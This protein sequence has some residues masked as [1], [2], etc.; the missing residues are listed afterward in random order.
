MSLRLRLALWYG[1]LTG[2]IVLL[3]SALGYAI[4]SRGQHAALDQALQGAVAHVVGGHQASD[5]QGELAAMLATPVLPD[6]SI[7]ITDAGGEV[8]AASPNATLAGLVEPAEVVRLA[9]AQ[10]TSSWGGRLSGLVHAS[11]GEGHFAVMVVDGVRWRLYAQ[12]A[13]QQGEYVLA[14]APLASMDAAD[15]AL[16]RLI[17][18]LALFGMAVTVIAGGLLA[19]RALR[20]LATITATAHE[21]A[22][23]GNPSARVPVGVRRDELGQL[24]ATFN[25]MLDSLAEAH[26]GQ[27][28]F[29]ADASH[30]L[31]APLTALQANLELL[32]RQSGSPAEQQAMIG[33]ASR[34]AH[35]LSRLVADLLALARADA[36]IPLRHQSVELDRVV[37]DAFREARHL[38]R[39]QRL[40]LGHF[41][42][43]RISGDP[44]RLKQVV[45][46]LLDNAIKYTAPEG[47]VTVTLQHDASGAR[48]EVRDS[49]VGIPKEALPHVWERFY[50]ADPARGRDPGGTGLGLPI[51][52]WIVE[53]HGGDITLT[54]EPGEGT[55]AR[56]WF[57]LEG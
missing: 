9:A 11:S 21:I 1:G 35:R 17:P 7:W 24:A 56:V 53:Q 8:L 37:L 25:E 4:H 44:D 23:S 22:H 29:V 49:G 2:A 15:A 55:T 32:E 46:I 27:Q 14:A 57:P 54:S 31:R 34:E 16:R 48:V 6:L 51:A 38:A 3:V 20:P 40:T 5:T 33:E 43:V 36:G 18:A 30:E 47:S 45:L 41:E 28:R 39:G 13:A 10:A 26:Q 42:P 19:G 12:P 50:R 52:R